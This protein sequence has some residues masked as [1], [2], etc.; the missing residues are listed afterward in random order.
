MATAES[1][2]RRILTKMAETLSQAAGR[3]LEKSVDEHQVA[4][5]DLAFARAELDAVTQ[6]ALVARRPLER[7]LADL[8][9]AEALVSLRGRITTRPAEY[10][11]NDELLRDTL[12]AAPVRSFV[13]KALSPATVDTIV[14]ALSGQ[15]PDR[16]LTADQEAF[17]ATF[18]AFSESKVGP[19]A[20]RIHREDL[21][22]PR[23][24]VDGLKE[25]GCFGLSIPQRYG[26]VQPDDHPDNMGMVVVTEELSRGSLAAAGSLITRPEILAKAL[27]KGGS[28]EQKAK[29]LPMLASGEAM[30]AVAV[31]EPD[32]GSDVAGIKVTA[33]R[34]PGGW[35]INGVKT[36]CTFAGFANVL[37]VLARTD[38]DRSKRHKGL[39]LFIAEKPSFEGHSF[40][41]SQP[42]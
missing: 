3:D 28:E 34:A 40:E 15:G 22:V 17:A 12:D 23:E 19:L 9:G 39:S 8:A 31:T 26:G 33:A 35:R 5:Y 20:E 4:V 41:A 16:G 1:A 42:G 21:L 27:L 25:L 14:E 32:H 10:G 24:I 30:A 2:G 37:M 6:A 29:W 13:E 36:W 18:R 38:P 11:V 7:G